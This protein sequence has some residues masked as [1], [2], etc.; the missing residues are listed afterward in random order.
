MRAQ[1]RPRQAQ[2]PFAAGLIP[3]SA[4]G[5]LRP[6]LSPIALVPSPCD[7]LRLCCGAARGR[8]QRR[9]RVLGCFAFVVPLVDGHY[10]TESLRLGFTLGQAGIAAWAFAA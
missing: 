3:Q 10:L 6:A 1:P 7:C 2:H 4:Q 8:S 5:A 9:G